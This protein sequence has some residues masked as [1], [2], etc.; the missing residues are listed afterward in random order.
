ANLDYTSGSS[1]TLS[2]VLFSPLSDG[3]VRALWADINGQGNTL[4]ENTVFATICFNVEADANTPLTISE[5]SFADPL[6]NTI[7]PIVINPGSV[8]GPGC[9]GG[10]PT[11]DD[12]IQNGQETGVDCG[13][14]ACPACP[15]CFDGIQNGDET[16]IDCGGS[17]QPCDTNPTCEANGTDLT[18]CIPDV[19]AAVGTEVCLDIRATNFTNIVGFQFDLNYTGANLEFTAGSSTV[20]NGALFSEI[21]DGTVRALW[22]DGAG[23]GNTLDEN[24]I[25]ATICFN[26]EIATNTPVT[27]SN[28]SFADPLGNTIDPVTINPG[29][30]NGPGCSGGG[31]NPDNLI[32]DITNADGLVGETVCVDMEVEN[33][34]ELSDVQFTLN[35]DPAV[36]SF[37]QTNNFGLSSVNQSNF[38]VGPAGTITFN[39]SSAVPNGESLADG[40]TLFSL[41]FTVDELAATPIEFGASPTPISA[42]AACGETAVVEL[43]NG[44][45]NPTIPMGDELILQIT[46]PEG[47]VGEEVC[48]PIRAFNFEDLLGAQFSLDFDPALLSYVGTQGQTPL[49]QDPI[50]VN[51]S[52]PGDIRMSWNDNSLQCQSLPNGTVLIELCFTILG[53]DP[54]TVSFSNSPIPIE[55]TDCNGSTVQNFTTLNCAINGSGAPTIV[56]VNVTP[57]TCHDASDASISLTVTGPPAVGYDWSPCPPGATG[58]DGPTISNIPAGTYTVEVRN[59]STGE[60]IMETIPIPMPLPFTVGIAVQGVTCEGEQDGSIILNPQGGASPYTVDWPGNLQDGQ[61]QQL[62]LDGGSYDITVTDANGCVVPFVNVQ[63]SEPE[64]PLEI[65]DAIID[66]IGEQPGS[67]TTTITGGVMP[68]AYSW[69]GPNGYTNNTNNI[70]DIEDSGT[71]C[72]TVLDNNNCVEIQCY[73][74]CETLR[75]ASSDIRGGCEGED[76][77]SI[78]IDVVGCSETFTFNWEGP[79]SFSAVTEDIFNLSPGTYSL[80][81][82][83]GSPPEETVTGTFTLEPD[84]PNLSAAS[85]LPASGGN[86]GAID[87][88][89]NGGLPPFDYQWTGPDGFM[90]TSQDIAN[91]AVGEYCV[92]V[93]DNAGCQSDT[94]FNVTAEAMSASV[95]SNTPPTCIESNDGTVV[96]VVVNGLAPYTVTAEPGGI[97]TS[98]DSDT[99][100][101]SLPAGT[102]DVTINGTQGGIITLPITVDE[103]SVVSIA[104]ISVVSD[105]EDAECTGSITLMVEGGQTPYE[106]TWNIPGLE[107]PQVNML[108]AGTYSP[109]IT[110]ANGCVLEASD[111]IIGQLTEEAVVTNVECDGDESGSIDL[112]VTGGEMP[113]TYAWRRDG[114]TETITTNEDINSLPAGTYFVTIMD[115]TGATVVRP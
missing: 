113:Y 89:V 65:T 95:L 92:T 108:C 22:A 110:D 53:N 17:C 4:P 73:L 86:T 55:F 115:A 56:D 105:T 91:L 83:N 96:I 32:L 63:V 44:M 12:G 114:E 35:Y 78:D 27:I 99:I 42:T 94:C 64:E 45:V 71:Y 3:T 85:I 33:F 74:V 46:C 88:S 15:T 50:F 29:S 20:L 79:N 101:L 8:N 37:A 48:V 39:W 25:V 51:N 30:V 14:P 72:L 16:G 2:G 107:G 43:M 41:C 68:Y 18:V 82:T 40:S 90:A 47:E 75:I 13:G 57:P 66:N 11:C 54:A 9:S 106:I 26:V 93:T 87:L 7:E 28:E 80:T 70:N 52:A 1:S 62:N 6:G 67:I 69:S 98:S 49:L 21:N 81:I 38:T 61:L 59:M 76:N 5:E 10:G 97:S 34:T 24:A 58:C 19:C 112:T 23:I 100:T 36:L 111:I 31:C 77:G 60:A 104:D 103:P 102:F 84:S 109:T